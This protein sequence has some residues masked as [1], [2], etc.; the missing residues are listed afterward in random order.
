MFHVPC[1]VQYHKV[2]LHLSIKYT[3]ILNLLNSQI[4][5]K[6]KLQV[7]AVRRADFFSLLDLM[8]NFFPYC[9]FHDKTTDILANRN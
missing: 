4:I 6:H 9:V 2:G 1:H 5:H 7:F 8:T 3:V